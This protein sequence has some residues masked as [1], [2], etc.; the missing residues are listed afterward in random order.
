MLRKMVQ[1]AIIILVV[2]CAVFTPIMLK[3]AFKG[4]DNYTGLEASSLVDN[5]ELSGQV[6]IVTDK[7]LEDSKPKKPAAD[8]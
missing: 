6:D 3:F 8:R 2:C 5:Y 1:M 7:L 4:E